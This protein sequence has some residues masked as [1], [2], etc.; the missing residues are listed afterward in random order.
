[1]KVLVN[2]QEKELT[3]F[4]AQDRIDI[5]NDVIINS[6]EQ[7]EYDTEAELPVMTQEQFDWWTEYLEQ[8]EKYNG[9]ILRL[10]GIY[11]AE[12]VSEIVAWRMTRS[13][14][15]GIHYGEAETA[16]RFGYR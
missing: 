1:M 5:A 12:K 7:L 16:L 13:E 11:G 3:C 15:P 8:A 14:I 6:G 4:F 9:E 10:K 2:G